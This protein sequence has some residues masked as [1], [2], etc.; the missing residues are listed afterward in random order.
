MARVLAVSACLAGMGGPA[1]ADSGRATSR[2]PYPDS[3]SP[4]IQG[5]MREYRRLDAVAEDLRRR[6]QPTPFDLLEL[7]ARI[8]F[9][10]DDRI[11]PGR[12]WPRR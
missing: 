4:S 10:L 3:V 5:M 9:R 11:P 2:T 8:L 6:G 1:A 12:P 7:Q